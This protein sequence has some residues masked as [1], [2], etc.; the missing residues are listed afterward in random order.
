MIAKIT[1]LA[2]FFVTCFFLALLQINFL[3]FFTILGAL[4]NVILT[5]FILS[6]F[7]GYSSRKMQKKSYAEGFFFA[8]FAGFFL[9][10]FSDRPFGI[11]MG[12][13]LLVFV[14]HLLA[15]NFFQDT[16]GKNTLF[17]FSLE[18][19]GLYAA[20]QILLFV[21]SRIFEF[22]FSLSFLLLISFAYSFC[23][24]ISGFFI[25]K[26]LFIQRAEDN[27]LKLL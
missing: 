16:Q 13:L 8:V 15:V 25:F 11:S 9:D 21:F 17:Y 18:F 27:Q 24:A 3:P 6:I 12:V 1:K 4:P 23:F 14:L 19:L 22:E 20:Y 7:F 2:L 26:K 5:L 10:V